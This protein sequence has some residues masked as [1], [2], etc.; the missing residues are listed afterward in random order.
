MAV[1]M[2]RKYKGKELQLGQLYVFITF[3]PFSQQMGLRAANKETEKT[4]PD[5]IIKQMN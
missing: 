1:W 4:V 2:A 3:P 5:E